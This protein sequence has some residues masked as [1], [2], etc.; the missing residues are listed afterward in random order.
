MNNKKIAI[1]AIAAIA[2][3]IT[4]LG[5]VSAFELFGMNL[6]GPTT[7][8][9]TKFMTGTFNGDVIQQKDGLIPMKTRSIT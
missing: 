8:F 1:I 3:I 2:L 9:D 5:A 4:S 6:F 7:D